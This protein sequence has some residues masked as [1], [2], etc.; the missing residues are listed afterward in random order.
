[1]MVRWESHMKHKGGSWVMVSTQADETAGFF[2][3][4]LG[5]RLIGSFLPPDQEA[6]ELMYWKE[7]R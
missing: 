2:Y 6:D 3:E 4:K 5:Y 1:M 7:L